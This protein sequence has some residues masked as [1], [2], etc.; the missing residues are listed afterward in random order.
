MKPEALDIDILGK[1][2]EAIIM[3]DAGSS[4]RRP[5][6]REL[7]LGAA[8][9]G[10]KEADEELGLLQVLEH[11]I[12]DGSEQQIQANIHDLRPRHADILPATEFKALR[13]TLLHGFTGAQL[14]T[15]MEE[16]RNPGA[17]A[18][19]VP[20]CPWV[21]EQSPWVL[22]TPREDAHVDPMLRG[23]VT[24]S[25]SRKEV[26]VTRLMRETWGLAIQE[27][28]QA[29]GTLEVCFRD[30]EFGLLSLGGQRWIHLINRY[31][32]GEG[33]EIG[34]V[35]SQKKIRISAPKAT[36]ESALA[37]INLRLRDAITKRFG[38]ADIVAEP[39]SEDVLAEVARI[40]NSVV[41]I[42]ES[43]K[44]LCVSWVHIGSRDVDLEDLG[45]QVFRLFISAFGSKEARRLYVPESQASRGVFVKTHVSPNTL[46]WRARVGRW[47]RWAEVV[48]RKHHPSSIVFK[49]NVLPWPVE[50]PI[51]TLPYQAEPT[52][53][54]LNATWSADSTV[55]TT[56]TFGHVLH[57]R[58][59]AS[60]RLRLLETSPPS[61]ALARVL[62]PAT[63]PLPYLAASSLFA[64]APEPAPTRSSVQMRFVPAPEHPLASR[65]PSLEL[66][67]D[68]R[69]PENLSIV[70]LKAVAE[71][72]VIDILLPGAPVDVRLTQTRAYTLPGKAFG[73]IPELDPL[74]VFLSKSALGF[75]D[76]RVETPAR[77]EGLRLPARMISGEAGPIG[78]E[79][80]TDGG[81]RP[82]AS[83]EASASSV[84]EDEPASADDAAAAAPPHSPPI[85]YVFAGLSV[86]RPVETSYR[87]WKLTF[88]TI[89][90]G[91][92]GGSRTE[93][94]LHAEPSHATIQ[95][96]ID[97]T[98]S[99]SADAGAAVPAAPLL[100]TYFMQHVALL[101]AGHDIKWVGDGA[102]PDEVAIE[103]EQQQ[104]S[105]GT[106]PGATIIAGDTHTGRS[107]PRDGSEKGEEARTT[108]SSTD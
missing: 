35:A 85:D 79:P 47:E 100:P 89:E 91:R 6:V 16:R 94:T 3:K 69:D 65:A 10:V 84:R 24:R 48:H 66:Y 106:A 96:F 105:P 32:L 37:A 80:A 102:A 55:S 33:D 30:V 63:P 68:L 92:G 53:G 45:D 83:Q 11:A 87:G 95:Q 67:V 98:A 15:Y 71:T 97:A 12:A 86:L 25:T 73:N 22:D 81:A 58:S 44:E 90:S 5:I 29:R 14:S 51:L 88:T 72:H 104:A 26:L 7:E 38:I 46:P 54:D 78:Q 108:R 4:R 52:G 27:F 93:M 74:Q 19:T 62:S 17:L 13:D 9:K 18:R 42:D 23:Y 59:T 70:G 56:A 101:A 76:G 57:S 64:S 99:P 20:E 77:V 49:K 61:A 82:A 34:L 41:Y 28:V 43:S 1:P 107:V 31:T 60:S 39:V 21:K 75:D 8:E 103:R 2:A 36:A 40:T 50:D